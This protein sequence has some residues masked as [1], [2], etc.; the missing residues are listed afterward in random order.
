MTDEKKPWDESDEKS[1]ADTPAEE[2]SDESWMLGKGVDTDMGGEYRPSAGANVRF[3]MK[4]GSERTVVFITD[5]DACPVV[6]E[7]QINLGG[8]WKNWL[9][10]LEPLGVP[11]PICKWA[12]GHDGQFS[13]YKG[14]FFTVIDTTEFKDS[15]GVVRKNERRLLVAKKEP[16]EII[17]RKFLTRL[18]AGDRLTGAMFKIFRPDTDKSPNVGSDYEFVKMVDLAD[19]P[20][21]AE[22]NY[23]ELLKP[24]VDRSKSVYNRLA[25]ERDALGGSPSGGVEEGTD[26]KVRY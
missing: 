2:A 10:C 1:S 12:N 20:E 17:K 8:S 6:Y 23:S 25:D 19:Y 7:H 21:S 22:F 16:S 14:Q 26:H 11:C 9:S 18:D 13:R 4:K 3:W 24:D 5:G 15:K